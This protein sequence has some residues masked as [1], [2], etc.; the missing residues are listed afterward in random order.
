MDKTDKNLI[1]KN[2][3]N[4]RINITCIG[5]NL[6]FDLV[7]SL[8]KEQYTNNKIIY[9]A[10]NKLEDLKE[11]INENILSL[12]KITSNNF[13]FNVILFLNRANKIKS[14][15]RYII[16]F[17]SRVSIQFDFFDKIIKDV[18]EKEGIEILPINIMKKKF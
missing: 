16:P 10:I 5:F 12:I 6:Q 2:E 4:N 13:L 15:I 18:L 7:L 8:T 17:V 3:V 11:K 1:N 9:N 14:N